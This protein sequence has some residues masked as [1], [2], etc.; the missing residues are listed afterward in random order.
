MTLVCKY[1]SQFALKMETDE[2]LK[3]KGKGIS[4]Q[5]QWEATT[6]SLFCA[7]SY[8]LMA[9]AAQDIAAVGSPVCFEQHKI[10]P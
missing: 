3:M 5:K 9:L 2:T 4:K 6:F 7:I 10:N 8:A 1:R